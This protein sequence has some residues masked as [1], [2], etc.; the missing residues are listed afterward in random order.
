MTNKVT[1]LP[2]RKVSALI[3]PDSWDSHMHVT[4]PTYPLSPTAAYVPATHTLASAL[5]FEA[6]Y[7]I[8]N[9][10][11]VQPSIYAADNACLVDALRQLGPSRGRA[12]VGIDPLNPPALTTL[13]A[14]HA[15]GVRGVRL[16]L[17]SVGR[18]LDGDAAALAAE[19]RAH[20]AAIAPLGTWVLQVYL[21]LHDVPLLEAAMAQLRA[22]GVRV[23]LCVDHFGHPELPQGGRVPEGAPAPDAYA[24][25]GFA[26]LVRLLDEGSTWVKVSGA[27]RIEGGD[28]RMPWVGAMARELLRVR[29]GRRCVFATDWPH[30]R[31]EGVDVEPFVE[32]CVEWCEG[33]ARRVERLFRANAEELWDVGR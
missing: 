17:R 32:K 2:P 4:D 15:L 29:D 23:K 19:L 26:S 27:Y 1:S 20:A 14:W 12:V 25:P 8:R 21:A 5:A 6:T 11:L 3:P 28:G 22:E 13:R 10:V 9:L 24:L 7:T 31:F 30:T 33:D 18:T 16:N